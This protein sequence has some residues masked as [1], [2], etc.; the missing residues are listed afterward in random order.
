MAAKL[1]RVLVTGGLS[2]G[3]RTHPATTRGGLR[4]CEVYCILCALAGMEALRQEI[5]R[6]AAALQKELAAW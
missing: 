6:T 5:A 3:H 4:T 2:C 1:V